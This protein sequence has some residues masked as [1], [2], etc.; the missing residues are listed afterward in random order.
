MPKKIPIIITL[1]ALGNEDDIEDFIKHTPW[2]FD[3]ENIRCF[4]TEETLDK[5]IESTSIEK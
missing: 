4:I 1:S 3:G 2:C 5:I